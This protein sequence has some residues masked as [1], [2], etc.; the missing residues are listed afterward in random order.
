MSRPE[1]GSGAPFRAPVAHQ[2]TLGR[3][4][5]A[6][7]P[8]ITKFALFNFLVAQNGNLGAP[9]YHQASGRGRL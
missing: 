3:R 4:K 6:D 8:G 1:L 5:S 9:S 2:S 7:L